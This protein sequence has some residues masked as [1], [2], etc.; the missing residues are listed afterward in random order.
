MEEVEPALAN[1]HLFYILVR[2]MLQSNV[3]GGGWFPDNTSIVFGQSLSLGVE[4]HLNSSQSSGVEQICGCYFL[5]PVA[6]GGE[7]LE[8]EL[9]MFVVDAN[10]LLGG[11]VPRN[12]I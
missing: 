7:P 6:E 10:L 9:I 3:G 12:C 5:S 2:L 4:M 1:L 11:L 8:L